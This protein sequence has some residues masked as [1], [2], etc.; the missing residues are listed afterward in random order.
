MPV[1]TQSTLGNRFSQTISYAANR[2]QNTVNNLRSTATSLSNRYQSARLW[3]A[4]GNSF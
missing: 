2:L 3:F 1:S 4:S